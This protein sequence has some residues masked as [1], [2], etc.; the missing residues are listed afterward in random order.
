MRLRQLGNNL[1]IDV[2]RVLAVTPSR[3]RT[4]IKS[5]IDVIEDGSHSSYYYSSWDP[6]QVAQ[7]VGKQDG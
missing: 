1:W 5:R 2:S 7:A 4:D 6:E 3:A